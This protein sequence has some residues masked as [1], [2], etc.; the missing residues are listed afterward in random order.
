M[1]HDLGLC[2]H[3]FLCPHLETV[4]TKKGL[5]L[6]QFWVFFVWI[7][8]QINNVYLIL[9]FN[10]CCTSFWNQHAFVL[11]CQVCSLLCQLLQNTNCVLF[12]RDF[13]HETLLW[14]LFHEAQIAR[15][16]CINMSRTPVLGDTPP[17]IGRSCLIE[18]CS[19]LRSLRYIIE[20]T[21]RNI[22][23]FLFS[24]HCNELSCMKE[25]A[26]KRNRCMQRKAMLHVLDG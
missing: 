11:E 10:M 22:W 9:S 19:S 23:T 26:G 1:E 4:S 20:S 14:G 2:K 18:F 6:V 15:E 25:C 21:T 8:F 24:E 17:K 13:I 16:Y 7:F 12:L 3:S 5:G